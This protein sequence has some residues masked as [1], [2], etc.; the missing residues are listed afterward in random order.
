MFLIGWKTSWRGWLQDLRTSLTWQERGEVLAGRQNPL[1]QR[2]RVEPRPMWY[3]ASGRNPQ[4]QRRHEEPQP[5]KASVKG[6]T[7]LMSGPQPLVFAE[8]KPILA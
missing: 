3:Q 5:N 2:R 6:K 8:P 4:P 7:A 1:P